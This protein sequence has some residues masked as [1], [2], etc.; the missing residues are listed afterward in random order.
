MQKDAW[1]T[2]VH[3]GHVIARQNEFNPM[4]GKFESLPESTAADCE[5][6]ETFLSDV[7][8]AAKSNWPVS[9]GNDTEIIWN[10][11]E[12]GLAEC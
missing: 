10:G 6:L 3:F 2:G 4:S 11:G 9:D 5:F 12:S 7:F 1:I 8:D